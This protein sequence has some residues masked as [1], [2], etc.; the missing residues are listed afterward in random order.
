MVSFFI[1]LYMKKTTSVFLGTPVP[2]K[3]ACCAVTSSQAKND[4]SKATSPRNA[5]STDL[6]PQTSC[7]LEISLP[8]PHFP[9][10]ILWPGPWAASTLFLDS[11]NLTNTIKFGYCQ[12]SL[13]RACDLDSF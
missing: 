4:M 10:V 3:R 8:L 5:I 6:T 13:L 9:A 2:K 12:L 11:I 1:I 7:N